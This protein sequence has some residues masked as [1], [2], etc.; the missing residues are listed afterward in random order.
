[1]KLNTI[2]DISSYRYAE[3]F[4]LIFFLIYLKYKDLT[5]ETL[6][7]IYVWWKSKIKLLLY[8][9]KLLIQNSKK[10]NRA[11]LLIIQK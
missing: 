8:Y 11:L 7:D 3:K 5:D 2:V 10:K 9:L 1:M 4:S 6:I